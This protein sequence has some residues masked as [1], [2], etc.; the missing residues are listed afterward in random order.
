MGDI[1]GAREELDRLGAALRAQLVELIVD[2]TP[3]TDLGLLFLDEP[4]VA[5]WTEPP[6]YHYS[7][8]IRG[9]RPAAVSAADIARRAAALLGAAGWEVGEAQDFSGPRPAV[10]VT[11]QRDGNSIEVRVGEHTSAVMFSGR[12]PALALREPKEFR[13]P[14]PVRTPETVTPGFVLCYEC[15][16]LGA[17]PECGGRGRLPGGHLCPECNG[18]RVC[19][20]CRGAGQLAISLLS[21]YQRTHYP[22]LRGGPA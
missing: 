17:C 4:T 15:D 10:V 20:I 9:E 14:D 16:G 11:G 19:P 12:T 3:G 22:E 5:D 6:R 7:G 2:L 13:L 18:T 21:S 1:S 8:L